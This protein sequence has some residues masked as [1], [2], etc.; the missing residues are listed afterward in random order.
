MMSVVPGTGFPLQL[1]PQR[2]DFDLLTR[3]APAVSLHQAEQDFTKPADPGLRA[4]SF[5]EQILRVTA[6]RDGA[7]CSNNRLNYR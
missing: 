6:F 2:A 3:Q 1:C 7:I 4:V 5:L